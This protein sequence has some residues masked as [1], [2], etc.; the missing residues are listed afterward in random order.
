M[1]LEEMGRQYI[2][3]SKIISREAKKLQSKIK[4]AHGKELYRLRRNYNTSLSIACEMK[5]TGK[6]LI[7]YYKE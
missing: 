5:F 6:Y 3:Q 2:E 1:T 7:H 4:N